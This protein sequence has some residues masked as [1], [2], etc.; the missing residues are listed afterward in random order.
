MV[1]NIAVDESLTL[2]KGRLGI[3]SYEVCE[4]SSGYLWQIIIC[5]GKTTD[6]ASGFVST[7]TL[8]TTQ[9]VVKLV[10]PLFSLRH[11]LWMDSYYNLPDLCLLLKQQGMNVPGTL[12]LNR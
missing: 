4:S 3:K 7:E 9:I 8:K 1:E 2:W 11:T 10:Q 12:Q 6:M 5:T